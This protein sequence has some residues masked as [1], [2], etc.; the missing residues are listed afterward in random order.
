MAA[1]QEGQVTRIL[2]RSD[3]SGSLQQARQVEE[4]RRSNMNYTVVVRLYSGNA[5]GNLL[6][7]TKSLVFVQ[8]NVRPATGLAGACVQLEVSLHNE[9][10][11][12][13]NAHMVDLA[14][15]AETHTRHNVS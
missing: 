11:S 4:L 13:Y 6:V 10:L 1:R 3:L 7:T 5:V 12:V 14:C 8:R 2:A 9:V 15:P